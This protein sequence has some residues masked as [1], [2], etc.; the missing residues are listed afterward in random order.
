[1][2]VMTAARKIDEIIGI[3]TAGSWEDQEIV[4]GIAEPAGTAMEYGDHTNIPLTSW[5]ANFER[6]TIVHDE[7][8]LLI[9]TLEEGRASAI[10][11][12]SAETKRQQAAIGL[13]IFRNAIGFYGWQSGLGNRTMV[14]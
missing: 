2:K 14:S 4:Q 11:L 9:G 13:E 1:M 6:R 12:N 8:G 5:N 10:R 7:L 3:D